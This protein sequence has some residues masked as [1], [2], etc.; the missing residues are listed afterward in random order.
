MKASSQPPVTEFDRRLL[1]LILA[2]VGDP[3]FTLRLWDGKDFTVSDGEP[4]ACIEFRNRRALYDLIASPSVGFG[5]CYSKGQIEVHGD[6]LIL[7][8]EIAT[9]MIRQRARGY[10]KHKIL[11]MLASMRGNTLSRSHHNVHHHYDLGNDFYK[12]WLDERLLYTCA[13]YETSEMDL[14]Q[15]QLEYPF[16][17]VVSGWGLL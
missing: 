3:R 1:R 13:Y 2:N 14:A 6:F 17:Y 5:E 15:A 7:A 12:L 9:A 4:V 16:S 10:W 11:S 8:N